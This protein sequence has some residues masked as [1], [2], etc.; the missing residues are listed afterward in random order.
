MSKKPKVFAFC[1]LAFSY[2]SVSAQVISTR[3]ALVRK[4]EGEV[5]YRCHENDVQNVINGLAFHNEDAIPMK[6]AN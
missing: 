3:A 5:F 1:I 4:V 2:L 6:K